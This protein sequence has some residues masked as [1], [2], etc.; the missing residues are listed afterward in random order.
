MNT[1]IITGKR[2]AGKTTKAIKEILRLLA[3]NDSCKPTTVLLLNNKETVQQLTQICNNVLPPPAAIASS[4]YI[5]MDTYDIS[6]YLVY[7]TASMQVINDV[8]NLKELKT[9]MDKHS[10]DTNI[11]LAIDRTDIGTLM[12]LHKLLEHFNNISD[13]II[14][15]D[16][17]DTFTPLFTDTLKALTGLDVRVTNL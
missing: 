5:G 9:L 7:R 8:S 4:T 14:T 17:L 11:I 3:D 15:Y 10:G 1:Q 13:L 6:S 12:A 2:R 16:T